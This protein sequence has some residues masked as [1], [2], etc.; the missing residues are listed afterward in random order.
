MAACNSDTPDGV[1]LTDCEQL[2]AH[3][4]ELRMQTVTAD[5]AQHRDAI[6]RSLEPVVATC[7]ESTTREQLRCSLAAGDFRSLAACTQ[8]GKS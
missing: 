2:R 1:S 7:A 6:H 5:H 4:V 8:G 3:M